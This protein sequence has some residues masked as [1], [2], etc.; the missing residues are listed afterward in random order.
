MLTVFF[1]ILVT[2][3]HTCCVNEQD[4]IPKDDQYRCVLFV[5][6]RYYYQKD[7]ELNYLLGSDLYLIMPSSRDRGGIRVF[8]GNLPSSVRE[9]DL[10][11][12]CHRFG[13]IRNIFLKHGKY[14]FCVSSQC[15]PPPR[16][17]HLFYQWLAP[18]KI[19][20]FVMNC[21]QKVIVVL[22][23][24]LAQ[25][26]STNFLLFSTN[27]LLFSTDFSFKSYLFCSQ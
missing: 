26:F 14:G 25:L 19:K 24:P 6:G 17:P 20:T 7:K 23:F 11:E 12:F 13:R 15:F 16:S 21:P 8:F 1:S 4:K 5:D 22:I 9:S 18:E 27:F 3:T 10:K 2:D